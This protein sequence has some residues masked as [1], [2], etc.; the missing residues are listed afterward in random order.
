MD[1]RPA[2]HCLADEHQRLHWYWRRW[3]DVITSVRVFRLH[4]ERLLEKAST[5]LGAAHYDELLCGLATSRQR[6]T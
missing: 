1:S 6:F 3:C 5:E 4:R 2:A